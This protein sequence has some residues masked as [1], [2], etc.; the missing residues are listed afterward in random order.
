MPEPEE[1]AEKV[2][3][4]Q[5]AITLAAHDRANDKTGATQSALMRH[6]IHYGHALVASE[7]AF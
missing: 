6:V 7:E 1:K 4:A 2:V 3:Y 5:K